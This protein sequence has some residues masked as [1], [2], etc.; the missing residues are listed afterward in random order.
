MQI[1]YVENL[2]ATI[3]MAKLFKNQPFQ[4]TWNQI[5]RH[6]WLQPTA[7]QSCKAKAEAPLWRDG[8]AK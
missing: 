6:F 8:K 7:A 3:C 5:M 2:H 1:D 4:S